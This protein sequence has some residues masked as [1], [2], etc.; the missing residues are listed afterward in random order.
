[1]K[2]NNSIFI[3]YAGWKYV[4]NPNNHIKRKFEVIPPEPKQPPNSLYKYFGLNKYSLDALR[5]GYLYASCPQELNDRFDCMSNLI[6]FSNIT[7]DQV[8][9]FYSGFQHTKEEITQDYNKFHKDFCLHYPVSLWAGF[10]IISMTNNYLNPTMWAHYASSNHGF[11]VKF[12]WV[13]FHE[14]ILGP[15]PINYQK[16]WI[17]IDFRIGEMISFLYMTNIKS[18]S[19]SYEDEWRFIGLRPKMSIPRFREEPEFINNRKFQYSENAIEEIILGNMFI[20]KLVCEDATDEVIKLK[21][22]DGSKI[23][24]FKKELL[25]TLIEKK[26]KASRIVLKKGSLSFEFDTEPIMIEKN[27]ETTYHLWRTSI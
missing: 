16:E 7:Q 20:D 17:P 27:D 8:F 3:E 6:D 4:F 5:K 26:I 1:M 21:F 18:L 13:N 2:E 24:K 9:D 19:W 22:V 25:D 14:H 11:T 12:K 15:F 10:G 23:S